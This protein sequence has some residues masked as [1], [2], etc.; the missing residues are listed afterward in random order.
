MK[1][2]Q[3]KLLENLI[4]I[5][6]P[7]GF[8]N[9]LAEF[10]KKE[11]SKYIPLN[12]ITIDFHNNVI[13][14]I[15]GTTGKTVMIDAHLD[16]IGF[17]VNNI[18]KEGYI[19]FIPIGGH[20]VN[21]LSGRELL[22]LAEKSKKYIKAV[23]GKK[24]IHLLND[25]DYDNLTFKDFTIDIGVRKR[26]QVNRY[27]SIG[28]PIVMKP[29]FDNLL[30][31]YYTGSGFDDKAG[32]FVLIE[33]IKEIL[34]SSKKSIPNLIFTFSSQE[35]LGCKGAK[36]LVRRFKPDLFI[37]LDVTF[38]T[39]YPDV[40]ERE[41]GRCE[42]GKGITL[43][44]GVNIDRDAL[45][46]IKSIARNNKIKLQYQ[47]TNSGGYNA[48]EVSSENDGIKILN[49]AIPL[50]NMHTNVEILNFKDL[51]SCIKLFKS[52]LL[53]RRLGKVLEK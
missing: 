1:N 43:Y 36:E 46:L 41:A 19:S 5:P 52:F 16:Q 23:I 18:D 31:N 6:S 24:P 35:E 50:R 7:S 4:K 25:N 39:D 53:N 2:K 13:V 44:K 10:I 26:N 11:L 30:E 40:D 22:I 32:C 33:T 21:L 3:I 37:G 49:V 28:D 34:R 48:D 14:K 8:E 47:A 29:S 9:K 38:A 51:I 20:D 27:I 15:K 12:I 17:L 45:K 42:L